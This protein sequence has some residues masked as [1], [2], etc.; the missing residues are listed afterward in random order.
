MFSV[1]HLTDT[2]IN[3]TSVAYKRSCEIL[4]QSLF[5]S[6]VQTITVSWV[7]KPP[8]REIHDARQ[9][10]QRLSASERHRRLSRTDKWNRA[11]T[12]QYWPIHAICKIGDLWLPWDVL[13]GSCG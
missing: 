2:D 1:L 7:R 12:L 10:W 13:T 11:R 6:R 8:F 5:A 4:R 3:I 9:T